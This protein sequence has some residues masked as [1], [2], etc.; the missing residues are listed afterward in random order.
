MT[1]TSTG[2]NHATGPIEVLYVED[3]PS[4]SFL[5]SSELQDV[6]FLNIHLTTAE[7]L[8]E[9]IE[10]LRHQR[11]DVVLLDLNLP[12]SQGLET[13]D[14]LHLEAPELPLIVLTGCDDDQLAAEVLSKGAQ[15]YLLKGQAVG[16]L[17]S[18]AVRFAVEQ[19]RIALESALRARKL[20]ESE[21][22]IRTIIDANIDALLIIDRNGTVQF[23]NPAA[24]QMFE[25][26]PV[27][28]LSHPIGFPAIKG[29]AEV[30]IIRG[31]GMTAIAEMRVVEITWQDQPVF[32]AS[33]RDITE[34]KRAQ[35]KIDKLNAELQQRMHEL[36][37]VNRELEA[38]SYS[39]AH[40]LRAPLRAIKGFS[41]ILLEAYALPLPPTVQDYLGRIRRSADNMGQLIDDLLN[42]SRIN[43]QELQ[44]SSV[45]L[46]TMAQQILD[47]LKQ[48]SPDRRL[49]SR[50]EDDIFTDG[51]ANLLRIVLVNLL[52]NAWKFTA[53]QALAKIEVG[54]V[55]RERR[56]VLFVRD[57]GAGFNMSY[58]YKLF[59]AF[60]RLHSE[61][62]FPGTGI[63]LAIVQRIISRHGG[64]VWAE[65]K[66]GEGSMF[67]FSI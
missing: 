25:R 34:H 5:I 61:D 65:S 6:P 19:R 60:Q 52:E 23:A 38:F 32:L 13:L 64:Q 42:L 41:K 1:N 67:Y 22:R 24:G 3:N 15:D 48:G 28:L 40:D 53:K 14:R 30:D 37:A 12:D 59:G 31:N 21:A 29:P 47:E 35:E 51:D 55:T 36:A 27:E 49:E 45:N 20:Q 10:H 46:S 43:R 63:G 4:D 39:V 2:F 16:R 50:V 57:N 66:I 7:R 18:N 54:V 8:A 9:A 26:E 17:L 44:R 56:R 58:A 62:E 33:L 11:F